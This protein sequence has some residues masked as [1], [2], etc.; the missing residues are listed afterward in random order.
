MDIQRLFNSQEEKIN[1]IQCRAQ[2]L[3]NIEIKNLVA[4]IENDISSGVIDEGIA[5]TLSK[6]KNEYIIM[7]ESYNENIDYDLVLKDIIKK[8]KTFI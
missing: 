3:I 6:N 5:L 7:R 2:E 1:Q 8:I 4:Q